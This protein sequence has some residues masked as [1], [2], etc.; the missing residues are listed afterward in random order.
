M[1]RL[2]RPTL[3]AA[4]AAALVG[5]TACLG[6]P[7]GRPPGAGDAATDAD[8]TDAMTDAPVNA[9]PPTGMEVIAI[10]AGDVDV[11]GEDDLIV[12]DGQT[13]RIYLLRGGVDLVPTRATVDTFSASAPLAGLRAPA[14]IAVARAGAVRHIVVLDSP[15][16]G[17]RLTVLDPSLQATGTSMLSPNPPTAGDTVRV[18]QSTFG[19]MMDAV[20]VSVP[21][22]AG[23]IEGSRLDDPAPQILMV[24]ETGVTFTDLLVVGGYVPGGPPMNPRIVALEPMRLHRAE[25]MMGNF[26]WTTVRDGS[27]WTSQT[28]HDV[29]GDGFVDVV[30]FAP[31]GG[32]P[33][34]ICVADFHSV[35]VPSP[36]YCFDTLFNMNGG[37]LLVGPI[38]TGTSDDVALLDHIPAKDALLFLIRNLQVSGG[39]LLADG[40]PPYMVPVTFPARHVIMQL[41]TGNPEVVVVG[42]DGEVACARASGNTF[43]ACAP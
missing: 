37:E 30:G 20:M 21:D 33:A 17:A 39:A 34:D 3:L 4:A 5:A 36:T 27:A 29:T 28:F 23:F 25:V 26:T 8:A 1:R 2:A 31:E 40:G 9:W 7:T 18:F 6:A 10:A 35:T 32:N 16:T 11:D 19:M 15:T 12:A 22:Q 14:S 13:A 42:T 24:A 43:A 41:D 38:A